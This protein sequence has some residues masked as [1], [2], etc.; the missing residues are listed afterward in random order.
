M[1]TLTIHIPTGKTLE[2]KKYLKSVGVSIAA[3]AQTKA[4]KKSSVLKDIETGLKQ[5]KAHQ[6]GKG[7]MYTLSEVLN[8]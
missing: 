5:V 2:V 8:G 7:E 6:E 4:A 3:T 1:T